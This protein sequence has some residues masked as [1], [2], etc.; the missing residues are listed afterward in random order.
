MRKW[1]KRPLEAVSLTV[2]SV[3]GDLSEEIVHYPKSCGMLA[4]N[5]VHENPVDNSKQFFF[6]KKAN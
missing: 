3:L 5:C 4:L 2:P 6:L 1:E